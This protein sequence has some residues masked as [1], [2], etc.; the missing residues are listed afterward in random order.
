MGKPVVAGNRGG[1]REIITPDV[2]G[3]LSPYEDAAALAQCI[4][5][6]LDDCEFTHQV[7]QSAQRRSYDFGLDRY[8]NRFFATV[9]SVIAT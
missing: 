4:L 6:Y 3:L 8:A 9:R 1:P 5:R 7:A 2:D